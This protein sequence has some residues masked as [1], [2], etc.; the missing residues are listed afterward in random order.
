[1]GK[2][3]TEAQ[4]IVKIARRQTPE[5]IAKRKAYDKARYAKNKENPEYQARINSE[6]HKAYQKAYHSTPEYYEKERQ[7]RLTPE[8]KIKQ[9]ERNNSPAIKAMQRAFNESPKGRAYYAEYRRRPEIKARQLEYSRRE[10]QKAKRKAY[11]QKEEAKARQKAYQSTE[12]YKAHRREIYAHRMATD[13][14][15]KL[16]TLI[17]TR[18]RR[19][20]KGTE[21]FGHSASLLG[22]SV[23]KARA[24][25]ESL[26]Q[27]GMTWDN[28]THDGWHLDHIRPVCSFDLTKAEDFKKCWHYTNLQPLWAKDNLAKNAT[29]KGY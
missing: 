5:Y 19:Y 14:D 18:V 15:F 6:A 2:E 11:S 9:R 10:D 21:M 25:I 24:H 26:F 8:Y 20:I 1:M 17:R 4:K 16:K 22:C 7:R 3:L 23:G 29:W 12:E 27:E 28:W 13:M